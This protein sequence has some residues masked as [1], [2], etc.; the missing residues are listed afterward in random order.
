[1]IRRG[2]VLHTDFGIVAYG[3]NTDTQHM[4][5]VLRDGELA[6]PDGLIAALRRSNRLQDI[7]LDEMEPGRTGNDVLRRTL[8][9]MRAEGIDGT[10]YTHPIGDHGHGAGPTIGLWDRQEGVVGRGDVALRPDT[11]YSI[12]LQAGSPIPEWEGQVVR[13]AQE[14]D[15]L[16][17]A[18]GT[19]RWVLRRQ[20]D[21][22]LVRPD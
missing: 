8:A 9:R 20:A 3:L 4:G 13:M 16:I 1:V 11:W 14:E 2:D 10:V 22:H 19:R 21:F 7:L 12:E 17:D 5:Y 18:G 6:P 15:A